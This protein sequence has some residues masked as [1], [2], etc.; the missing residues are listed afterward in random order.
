MDHMAGNALPLLLGAAAVLF[1]M[2]K[3]DNGAT[4]DADAGSDGNGDGN[5][6]GNGDDGGNGNGNGTDDGDDGGG[7]GG[8]ITGLKGAGGAEIGPDT[9]GT[10][11]PVGPGKGGASAAISTSGICVIYFNDASQQRT[12]EKLA[13]AY[14]ALDAEDKAAI[15]ALSNTD[16]P[17]NPV[18]P[19]E[20][21]AFVG[22]VTKEVWPALDRPEVV[23]PPKDGE[24]SGRDF[25]RI[26]FERVYGAFVSKHCGFAN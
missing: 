10:C 7:G 14:S 4:D 16:D 9:W 15:C 3:K 2:K 8:R 23:F 6:N 5:G 1:L 17:L 11:N 12:E 20:R 21:L 24:I 19:P 25:P 26:A 18:D 13:A 22:D